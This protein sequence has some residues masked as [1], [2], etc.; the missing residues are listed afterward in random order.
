MS[1]LTEHQVERFAEQPVVSRM[2]ERLG[3]EQMMLLHTLQSMLPK[4]TAIATL[5]TCV[6]VSSELGLNPMT[7]E[8]FFMPT[9]GGGIQ[10][11]ISVDGWIKIAQ[12][13]PD[14]DGWEFKPEFDN[15][16][17]V[18]MEGIMYHK[19][20]T[21]PTMITEYFDECSKGGA[22]WKSHPKRMMRNRTISQLVRVGLGISGVMDKDEFDQWQATESAAPVQLRVVET[23]GPR[24]GGYLD[25]KDEPRKRPAATAF[26]QTGGG[27]KFNDLQAAIEQA[28]T[29]SDLH[30]CFDAFEKNAMPWAD[31]PIG[32]A[33]LLQDSYSHRLSELT[34]AGDDPLADQQGLIDAIRDALDAVD[35]KIILNEIIEGNAELVT[36]CSPENR[37]IIGAMYVDHAER[38]AG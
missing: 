2:A 8:I 28:M 33:K 31:Y 14:F 21:H 32:W 12:R 36:R 37:I 23:S 27:D 25:V 34:E 1:E 7:K 38:L 9:R 17:M 26:S 18:S 10:P 4:G 30:A 24:G 35:S 29:E 11:V 16:D 3:V 15:K 6:G 19:S 5:M 22:V 13:H 20:R